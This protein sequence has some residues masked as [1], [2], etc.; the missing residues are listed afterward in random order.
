MKTVRTDV[1]FILIKDIFV[2]NEV[3]DNTIVYY[4]NML[5]NILGSRAIVI[6]SILISGST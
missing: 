4:I 5:S 3:I 1:S 6:N 2:Y